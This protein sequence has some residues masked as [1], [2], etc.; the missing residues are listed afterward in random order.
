M[1]ESNKD[2]LIQAGI[3]LL[4]EKTFSEI[5]MDQVAE[6]SGVS[7]PMIYYYFQNKEGYYKALAKY[8]LRMAKAITS[9]FF[10][11]DLPL[12]EI[13][14]NYVRF[15]IEFVKENPGISKAFISMFT[16][17]NIG[18]LIEDLQMEFDAMRLEMIDP[19]F[20]RALENGEIS[21]DTNRMLVLMI[22]NSALLACSIK[23]LN[24]IPCTEE[25]N[26]EEIVNVLFDGILRRE[27][28]ADEI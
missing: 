1:G 10:T 23:I 20:E 21:P 9:R 14:T 11:A 25:F 3:E 19:L 18:T 5:S 28:N 27:E 24:N 22:V 6:S 15:R 2:K 4:S 7:K 17:P 26:P 12:R 13:L 8:L 16:D